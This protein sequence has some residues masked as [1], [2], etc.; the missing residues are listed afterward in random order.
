MLQFQMPIVLRLRNCSKKQRS[1]ERGRK[2]TKRERGRERGAVHARL[3]Q[4]QKG[5]Q[6]NAAEDQGSWE[7]TTI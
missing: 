4:S 5:Q 1:V 2:K 6:V 3:S 7:P